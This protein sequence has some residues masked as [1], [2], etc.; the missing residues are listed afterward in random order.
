MV[1]KSR[2]DT[3]TLL[4]VESQKLPTW[5]FIVSIIEDACSRPSR[6][7]ALFESRLLALARRPASPHSI[8][9]PRRSELTGTA[10]VCNEAGNGRSRAQFDCR[11]SFRVVRH[12]PGSEAMSRTAPTVGQVLDKPRGRKPRRVPPWLENALNLW[13][14]GRWFRGPGVERVQ[15]TRAAA[16]ETIA[17]R[18][19]ACGLAEASLPERHHL[20]VGR[21]LALLALNGKW[22]ARGL[23]TGGIG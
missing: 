22:P 5:P 15:E 17:V 12:L 3:P 19:D 4:A 18:S 23:S 1:L 7:R 11:Q 2:A 6:M 21:T 14:F 20:A 9:R 16:G 10:G 13:E 8:A